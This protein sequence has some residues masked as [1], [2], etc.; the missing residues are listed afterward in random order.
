MP[1][2]LYE[3]IPSESDIYNTRDSENAETYY[4]RTD[5]FKY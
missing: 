4:C 1:K 3:L 5:Q 2:Y